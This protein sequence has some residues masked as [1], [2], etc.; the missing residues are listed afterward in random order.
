M[1]TE[2]ITRPSAIVEKAMI[3][4]LDE[5]G[6]VHPESQLWGWFND[7]QREVAL[8]VPEAST[9]RTDLSLKAGIEQDIPSGSHCLIDIPRNYNGAIITHIE[10]KVL[11]EL[12]PGWATETPATI[13]KHYIYDKHRLKYFDVYPP[14]AIGARVWCD[15]SALPDDSS[16]ET[17]LMQVDIKFANPLIDY[18]IFRELNKPGGNPNDLQRAQAHLQ[19]FFLGCGKIE[20]N[21]LILTP[22]MGKRG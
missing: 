10:R 3:L 16:Y 11:N 22:G 15:S 17:N 9:V 19:A 12:R 18:I 5:T 1:A 20:E 13:I 2:P 21:D 8:Q 6:E 7:G 4:L 14:A